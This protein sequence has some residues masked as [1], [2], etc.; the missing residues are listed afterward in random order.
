MPASDAQKRANAKYRKNNVKQVITR[1][2][3]ADADL[4][5]FVKSKDDMSGYIKSL[6]RADMERQ[7]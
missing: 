6:I 1:F 2:Y 5:E 4:Y 3:P 7:G